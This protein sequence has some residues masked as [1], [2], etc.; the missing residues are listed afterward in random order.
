VRKIRPLSAA[1]FVFCNWQQAAR[2]ALLICDIYPMEL[3]PLEEAAKT[4]V[5][6]VPL[7]T[8]P[9]LDDGYGS[10]NSSPHN[11]TGILPLQVIETKSNFNKNLFKF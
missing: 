11:T 2:A 3:Q 10:S 9:T 1:D 5:H 8:A 4:Q 7:S 6:Q